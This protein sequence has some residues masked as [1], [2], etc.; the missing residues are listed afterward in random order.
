M[1]NTQYKNRQLY[2]LRYVV[3]I[4]LTWLGFTSCN[5]QLDELRPHNVIFEERQF[6][7]P[8]GYSKAV[9]GIYNLIAVGSESS[10]GVGFTDLQIFLSEARGNTIRALDAQVNRNTD[11]FDYINSSNR[12]LSYTYA[13]WRNSYNV[14]L[15]INKVLANVKDDEANPVIL[16]AKAEALFLRGYIYFNLVRL[17]GMPFYQGNG[18][19]LGVMLVVND[20]F[21]PGLAPKRATVAEI[22]EQVVS[23]LKTSVPLFKQQKSNSY[24]SSSAAEALLSRVELYRGGTFSSPN[25]E[26]NQKAFEYA[27]KVIRQGGYEL[28]QGDAFKK[29][30]DTDNLNNKEDIFAIN[31]EFMNGLIANLFKMPSQINYTG[32]LYRPSPYLLSLFDEKDLRKAFYVE[33]ITPGFPED[34]LACNK[35]NIGYASLYSRS[36]Y[37]YLRLA[38]MYLNRA[39]ASVKLGKNAAALADVNIIRKRAGLTALENLAGEALFKEIL[40]QRKIELAFEGHASYD[41][42]RNGLSMVRDYASGKSSSMTVQPTEGKILMKIPDEEIASNP[43]LVQNP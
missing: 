13:F 39:E 22:Y 16:Q 28:I 12:D 8:S 6:D 9:S 36:P 37:R 19:S 27:D 23:D 32:G 43:N 26:A 2:T 18:N 14:M 4:A 41:E 35:Y 15:H 10:I 40:K 25:N 11:L 1:K 30:Y 34:H 33:N 5:K 42:F 31:G 21:A 20:E 38:E 7:T 3:L 24:A 29:Y 17:Y